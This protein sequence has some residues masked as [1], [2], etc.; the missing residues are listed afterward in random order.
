MCFLLYPS[1]HLPK[2]NCCLDN[3]HTIIPQL[4]KWT[5]SKYDVW[6]WRIE[7]GSHLIY[8]ASNYQSAW[9]I[10]GTQYMFVELNFSIRDSL[11]FY[12]LWII[13]ISSFW[14]QD[15]WDSWD[16]EGG[17]GTR[18]HS[19]VHYWVIPTCSFLSY[20]SRSA[21]GPAGSNIC[22]QMVKVDN[23]VKHSLTKVE[24]CFRAGY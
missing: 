16:V 21:P 22:C 2:R 15:H 17:R 3:S 18:A 5:W 6:S 23:H 8:N 20:A 14:A 7:T 10:V 9:Y 13:N 19:I 24:H 4:V 12:L 11:H 1:N